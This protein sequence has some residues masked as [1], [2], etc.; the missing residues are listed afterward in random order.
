ME[1]A[2][3]SETVVTIY[4]ITRRHLEENNNLRSLTAVKTSKAKHNPRKV[5]GGMEV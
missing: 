5:S 2:L 3:S 1:V 4:R